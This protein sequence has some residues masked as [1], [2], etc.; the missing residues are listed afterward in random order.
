LEAHRKMNKVDTARKKREL[1]IAHD[2]I[3]Q[4]KLEILK[5]LQDKQKEQAAS[6]SSTS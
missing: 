1:A 2:P 6:S 5:R 3:I 4:K